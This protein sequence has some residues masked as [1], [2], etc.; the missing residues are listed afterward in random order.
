MRLNHPYWTWHISALF[1]RLSYIHIAHQLDEDLFAYLGNRIQGA[2]VADCGCGPGVVT[3]KF[4]RRGAARVL[5]IDGNAAMLRQVRSR[6]AN[7]MATDQVVAVQARFTVPF[8]SELRDR[9]L[10]GEGFDIV[11]FKR[12]LYA[13]LTEALPIL[14]SAIAALNSGGILVVIHP[15]RLLRHYAFGPNLRLMPYTPYHLFNRYL[16]LLGHKLDLGEYTLYT[17][18]ELLDLVRAAGAG[19]KVELIPSCQQ[20]Y[21][22]VAALGATN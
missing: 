22:L 10:A 4:L 11:L 14:Q 12:S 8:F 5:A 15:D 13:R 1:Y 19:R 20:A 18:A 7:F 2:I 3:E 21:N 16:S 9:F 17:Q 6:L